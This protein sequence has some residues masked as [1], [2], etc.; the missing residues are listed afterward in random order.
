MDRS[1]PGSPVL[2][3]PLEFA[4]IHVTELVMPSDRLILC[5]PPLLWPSIFLSIRVFSNESTG[6]PERALGTGH[7]VPPP[8]G[9]SVKASQPCPPTPRAEPGLGLWDKRTSRRLE[10]HTGLGAC[11]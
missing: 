4:Q 5:R 7:R 1:M 11:L 6:S 8:S 10:H 3:R 9:S 2:H